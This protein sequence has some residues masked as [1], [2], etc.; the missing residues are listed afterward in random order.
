MSKENYINKIKDFYLKN[1]DK[2]EDLYD[3]NGDKFDLTNL[4]LV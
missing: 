3:E 1:S 2:S 4:K